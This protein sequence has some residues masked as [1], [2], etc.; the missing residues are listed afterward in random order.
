MTALARPGGQ[1]LHAGVEVDAGADQRLDLLARQLADLANCR[2]ALSDDDPLLAFALDVDHDR[3]VERIL[4]LAELVDA[5]GDAVGQLVAEELHAGFSHQL[6][7]KESQ[8][9]GRGLVGGKKRG[10][11]GEQLDDSLEQLVESFAAEGGDGERRV[12]QRPDVSAQA[13]YDG[14]VGEVALV[15]GD[16]QRQRSRAS[17]LD[18]L[19]IDQG[20]GIAR[21]ADLDDYI[22]LIEGERDR[23]AH[24]RLERVAWLDQAGRVD[25]E[26]LAALAG[27]QSGDAFPG[28]LRS[29][30]DDAQV[31]A[32]QRVKQRRLPHIRSPGQRDVA[33]AERLAR[34]RRRA[35]RF[36]CFYAAHGRAG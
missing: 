28:G 3:D 30:G 22:G 29:A 4:V 20:L 11:L 13:L 1:H 2:A 32:H 24:R 26:D 35:R 21:I 18:R 6:P 9:L 12:T 31:L 14:R 27:Q 8:R 15:E 16:D 33:T 19:R 25:K 10:R 7:D 5:A 34:V 17:E 23:P 36:V